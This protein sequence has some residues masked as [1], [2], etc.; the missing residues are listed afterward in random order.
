[1]SFIVKIENRE[2]KFCWK[3][4][5]KPCLWHVIYVWTSGWF[6]NFWG[7]FSCVPRGLN[8]SGLLGRRM[9]KRLVLA[10]VRL[11][12]RLSPAENIE[13]VGGALIPLKVRWDAI[14]SLPPSLIPLGPPIP[15]TLPSTG[16]TG[17]VT[18]YKKTKRSQT[19]YQGMGC[20]R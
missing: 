17:I 12:F 9:G 13:S 7:F 2:L 20:L 8:L 6:L 11:D 4:G 16:S 5:D 14:N 10:K 3:N 19:G 18:E 15:P 1:M